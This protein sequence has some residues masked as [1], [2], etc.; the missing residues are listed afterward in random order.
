MIFLSSSCGVG[1]I[2]AFSSP[3]D[4]HCRSF[5]SR[6]KQTDPSRALHSD[7][8]AV[9]V[10]CCPIYWE[11]GDYLFTHLFPYSS[12]S[13]VHIRCSTAV[14]WVVALLLPPLVVVTI[15]FFLFLHFGNTVEYALFVRWRYGIETIK[16]IAHGLAK[17]GR[18]D[19]T[20]SAHG[21][22]VQENVT[23]NRH[24][25]LGSCVVCSVATTIIKWMMGSS[26]KE[27]SERKR[28]ARECQWDRLGHLLKLTRRRGCV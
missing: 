1:A 13:S 27:K 4:R 18:F 26:S 8:I 19:R 12:P 21:I 6:P 28:M 3:L 7:V 20:Q 2:T 25:N 22:L 15:T 5:P 11:L 16:G 24:F 23:A 14:A 9:V 10:F 17:G